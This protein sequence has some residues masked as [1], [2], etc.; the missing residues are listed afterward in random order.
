[1]SFLDN[2]RGPFR[3][4]VIRPDKKA[5]FGRSEWLTGTT[6]RED[7]ESVARA[8]LDDPRDTI[9]WVGVWSETE[10]AFCGAYS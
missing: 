2:H 4:L 3:F 7:I 6:D 1:M 8:L 9:T 5:G 10:Q